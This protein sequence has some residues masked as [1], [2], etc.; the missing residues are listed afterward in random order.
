MGASLGAWNVCNAQTGIRRDGTIMMILPQA[1]SGP[2]LPAYVSHGNGLNS[3]TEGIEIE[4][5]GEGV[6]GNSH[7][8]WKEGGGPY[9]AT[10]AQ[11]AAARAYL[12]MRCS[13]LRA[14]GVNPTWIRAHR[15]SSDQR[16]CD[17]GE[18]IWREVGLWAIANLGLDDGGRDWQTGTGLPLPKAW[19]DRYT[20]AF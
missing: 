5:N 1:L 12:T 7:T 8:W 2:P 17:P 19:G 3:A 11:I 20:A 14:K 13:A 4:A 16:Q 6:I 18:R 9:E 15:Q 10:D